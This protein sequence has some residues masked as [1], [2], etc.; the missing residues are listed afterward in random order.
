[1]V[2]AP[3]HCSRLQHTTANVRGAAYVE[4]MKPMLSAKPE[5]VL[6]SQIF[7]MVADACCSTFLQLFI[8]GEGVDHATKPWDVHGH[9]HP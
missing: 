7:N 8:A 9:A 4:E 5:P 2:V 6:L 3:M 1:M